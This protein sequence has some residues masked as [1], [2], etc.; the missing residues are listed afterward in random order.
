MIITLAATTASHNVTTSDL[1]RAW[2]VGV[3]RVHT[4]VP[5]IHRS[6]WKSITSSLSSAKARYSSTPS[7]SST[8]HSTEFGSFLD[9]LHHFD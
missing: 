5:S 8:H 1:G 6:G 2:L 9:A 7:I 4:P 3:V